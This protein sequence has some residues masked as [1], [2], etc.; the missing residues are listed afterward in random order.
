MK[1]ITQENIQAYKN[2]LAEEEKSSLTLE[3]YIRDIVAFSNWIGNKSIE[4][5]DV[6]KYKEYL[7][8]NYAPS[9]VNS[10]LSSINSFFSFNE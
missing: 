1:T 6:L 2:Y 9:S 7:T 8:E 5:A 4:K 10:M 3:K